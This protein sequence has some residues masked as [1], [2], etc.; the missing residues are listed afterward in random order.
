MK[1]K[2]DSY[3]LNGIAEG[4]KYCVRGEKL[5]LF[6]TGVCKRNCWYCSLSNKRKNKDLIFANERECKNVKDIIQEVKDSRATSAGITGGDPLIAFDRTIK[7]ASKLKKKFGKNFHIHI[8]L[9]TKFITAEKLKKL[10]KYVDE[11]RF[12]PAFLIDENSVDKDIEKIRFA[13]LFWN[14]PNIGIELPLIPNKKRDVLN[15]IL[16]IKDYV[17]FVNLNE[18]ELSE[19]NFDIVTKNYKLNEGGYVVKGSAEAGKWILE[20]LKKEKVKLNIHLC[21]AE[22]KNLHQFKN[23]LARHKIFPYGKRTEDGNVIYLV[24]D[25]KI[26]MKNTFY[27]K[28]KK[29]TI[30]SEEVAKKL[31]G[32]RKIMRVEE[33]P[34]RD[35]IEIESEEI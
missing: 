27:D 3:C 19:T 9:P 22:L 31:L 32:K 2:F 10:S 28:E 4:C 34:T 12:H 18:F 13:G 14:K 33:F 5:V 17:G 16:K 8:Y 11:V 6:V 24:T 26:K 25:G 1:T 35:R 30:L 15:F 23:R 7:F 29:R 20:Q 21:T